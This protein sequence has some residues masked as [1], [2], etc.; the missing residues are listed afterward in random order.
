MKNKKLIF[1][2]IG[3]FL[4]GALIAVIVP[5]LVPLREETNGIYPA[6]TEA[7]MVRSAD[8]IVKGRFVSCGKPYVRTFG[9]G[10]DE[11]MAEYEYTRAQFQITDVIAGEPYND[12]LVEIR[13]ESAFGKVEEEGTASAENQA[14]M[15]YAAEIP[16]NG[17][18]SI[19]TEQDQEY[20]LILNMQEAEEY[21]KEE[22]TYYVPFRKE[23][24]IYF[25]NDG[26]WRNEGNRFNFKESELNATIQSYLNTEVE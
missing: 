13:L 24:G 1:S 20:L 12:S 15:G 6:I 18:F 16:L 10:G 9:A 2:C 7:E 3:V 23:A 19:S 5:Q 22:G 25:L 4:I 8:L 11:G 21:T 14:S 26:V 17:E